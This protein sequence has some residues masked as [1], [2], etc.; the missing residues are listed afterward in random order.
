[1]TIFGHTIPEWVIIDLVIV[2]WGY[3][4]QDQ[5]NAEIA[6]LKFRLRD[7]EFKAKS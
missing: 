4:R 6:Q 7:L 2:G 3:V 1:M 5:L